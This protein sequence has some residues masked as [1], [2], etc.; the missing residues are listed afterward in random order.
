MF[1]FDDK[2]L[3]EAGKQ[4]GVHF[5]T[6]EHGAGAVGVVHGRG[7][8]DAGAHVDVGRHV[9]PQLGARARAARAAA[10]HRRGRRAAKGQQHP[11]AGKKSLEARR[12]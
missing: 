5:N 6:E 1:Q 9:H 10:D 4:A 12:A 3:Q 7:R 8:L 11:E 2:V